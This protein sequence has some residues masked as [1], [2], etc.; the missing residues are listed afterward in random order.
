MAASRTAKVAT[1]EIKGDAAQRLFDAALESFAAIGY[2]ATTTRDIAERAGMSPAAVYVHYKSKLDLLAAIS[3]VGHERAR[4]CLETA[5]ASEGTHRERLAYAVGEFARW[6]AE[7]QTLARVVQYEY[8][9]LPAA[10]RRD[11]K[12]LRRRMQDDIENEVV[13][14][15]AAGEFMTPDPSG[16]ALA[17]V[18]LCVDIA[19]WYSPTS[20]RT[21]AE[22]ERLYATLAIS[23]VT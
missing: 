23:M 15:V 1:A 5:L 6:H 11:I 17:V 14:G 22:L 20:G 4:E 3:R 9:A 13:A 12:S 18:S 16:A 7:N 2:H 10:R 21:P 19:R 8:K